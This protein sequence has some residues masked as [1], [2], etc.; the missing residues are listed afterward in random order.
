M[1]AL[2]KNTEA[3]LTS[4]AIH[5]RLAARTLEPAHHRRDTILVLVFVLRGIAVECGPSRER[6]STCFRSQFSVE[7][8]EDAEVRWYR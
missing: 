1:F 2:F 3:Q 5:D 7:D 6:E 4:T 8:I